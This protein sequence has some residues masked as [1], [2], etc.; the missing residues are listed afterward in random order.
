MFTAEVLVV[1]R[2]ST[3][4]LSCSCGRLTVCWIVVVTCCGVFDDRC[5]LFD[6]CGL[7]MNYNQDEMV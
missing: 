3:V 4:L 2:S 1:D 6:A 5:G 7:V